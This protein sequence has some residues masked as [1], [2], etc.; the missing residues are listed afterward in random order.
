MVSWLKVVKKTA[1]APHAIEPQA[2]SISV[3]CGESR[4]D[5]ASV[6][7]GRITDLSFSSG[8]G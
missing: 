8:K 7:Q 3:V 4:V 6:A 1:L 2:G 5:G